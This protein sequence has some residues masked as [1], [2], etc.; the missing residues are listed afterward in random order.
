MGTS[1]W[2]A[3]S[4]SDTGDSVTLDSF[5]RIWLPSVR[6]VS[7]SDSSSAV[8]LLSAIHIDLCIE[9]GFCSCSP[10]H[11]TWCWYLSHS[12]IA[13]YVNRNNSASSWHLQCL[14]LSLAFETKSLISN[15]FRIICKLGDIPCKGASMRSICWTLLISFSFQA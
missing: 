1:S 14:I 9:L 8:S 7:H 6:E 4:T 12:S 13:W 11:K 2:V 3:I 10:S 5:G 15:P